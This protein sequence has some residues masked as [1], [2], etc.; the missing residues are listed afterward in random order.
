MIIL[1]TFISESRHEYFLEKYLKT[2]PE[3]FRKDILK[4][5]RWE[6]AQLS[7]LGRVLLQLGLKFHYLINDAE[8][9]RSADNKPYL[10]DSHLHFNISHSK[11]LV[12]CAIAEFPIGI[13]IEFIDPKINYL[14]FQYQMTEQEFLKIDCSEDRINAFFS[15]WT[16]KEAVMKAHGGGMMIPLDSF[17]IIN[18]ECEIDSI[19]FFTK[20]I[21]IDKNYQSSIASYDKTLKNVVPHF[22]IPKV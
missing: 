9:L 10:K 2:F 20:D 3:D 5:R 6:D 15:Y 19:K 17:E 12:V 1:H 14:D 22:L 13:D 18:G 4:Y 21:F 11:E 7:L 8:I 16:Q